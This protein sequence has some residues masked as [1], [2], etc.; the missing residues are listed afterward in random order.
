MT[1]ILLAL[2]LMFGILFISACSESQWESESVPK[3]KPDSKRKLSKETR[4]TLE[5]MKKIKVS[6]T[7]IPEGMIKK[8]L[9]Y[10]NQLAAMGEHEAA[11][12]ETRA[13]YPKSI[14]PHQRGNMGF[15]EKYRQLLKACSTTVRS[16]A[17]NGTLALGHFVFMG[18]NLSLKLIFAKKIN[19]PKEAEGIKIYRLQYKGKDTLVMIKSFPGTAYE[20]KGNAYLLFTL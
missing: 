1:R 10:L 15:R 3:K 7:P 18:P 2:T 8:A 17:V 13:R 20:K 14:M 19:S 11:A 9:P 6:D 5:L 12:W 4:K 16:K